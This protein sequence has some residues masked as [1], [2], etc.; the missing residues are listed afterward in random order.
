MRASVYCHGIWAPA[1]PGSASVVAAL[2]SRV[3][4]NRRKGKAAETCDT[5]A[6]A[7]G[8]KSM[9]GSADPMKLIW[10]AA[11]K[12]MFRLTVLVRACVRQRKRKAA[13]LAS[14]PVERMLRHVGLGKLQ[15][16]AAV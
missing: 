9:S 3:K 14:G 16:H 11:L 12:R 13:I 2:G 4:D 10:S 6:S 7:D 5:A 8:D 15:G 1:A